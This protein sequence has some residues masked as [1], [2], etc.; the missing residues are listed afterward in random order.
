MSAAL[1]LQAV[2]VLLLLTAKRFGGCF[3]EVSSSDEV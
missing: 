3:E 2:R 1:D